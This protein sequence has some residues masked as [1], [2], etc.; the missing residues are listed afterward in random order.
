MPRIPY[1]YPEPGTSPAAD[2]IRERR[3]GVLKELDGALLNAP[4]IAA[5]YSGLLGAVR[6]NN[7]LRDDVRELVML[8]VAALNGAV[9]E[10]SVVTINT[11]FHEIKPHCIFAQGSSL[12]ACSESGDES[13]ADR[14][15]S[16]HVYCS[17]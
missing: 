6:N 9:Y 1:Q 10:W 4:H 5:G 2:K 13:R 16:G 17:G 14:G 15:H 11:T 8:R 12:S 7:S 3:G